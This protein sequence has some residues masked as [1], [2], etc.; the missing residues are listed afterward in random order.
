MKIMQTI[1]GGD[2]GG[3]EEF[4]V[5]LTRAFADKN[6][7]QRVV[8]RPNRSRYSRL[9]S[10]GVQC[11]ELPFGGRLDW[12]TERRLATQI[13][14]FNP[15]IVLS[16]MSRATNITTKAIARA[17]VKPISI[18]R[19]GGYYDIK[20]YRRCDHLIGNT[21][22]IVR[23]LSECGWP[24]HRIHYVP[25]FV[26]TA[27]GTLTARESLGLPVSAPVALAAGRLHSNKGFDILL[28]AL[29]RADGMYLILAGEGDDRR[30]LEALAHRLG[31]TDRTRFLG[32]RDDIAD[33]MASADML[34]CSSRVEPLG[35]V[36]LEAWAC[37]LPVVAAAS[38]GPAWLVEDG[39]DG[40]LVPVE[41][42]EALAAAMLLVASDKNL[43]VKLAAAGWKRFETEFNEDAVVA[44]F[45][46]M[47]EVV[48]R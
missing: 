14:D 20:N 2:A 31:V 39:V 26:D 37:R 8:A 32:W 41:D 33:L 29:E 28:R 18:G 16:W 17:S 6:L 24:Q 25:N 43:A 21:P 7:F 22:D 46:E 47:F 27:S 40:L 36:L 44:R 3:A 48:L 11:V 12:R 1:A 30:G 23:Y 45:V 38:Q 34:V 10:V 5:R 42:P 15:D 4:F 19:L 9:A 13:E 35:N